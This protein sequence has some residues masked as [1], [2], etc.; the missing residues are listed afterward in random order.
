MNATAIQVISPKLFMG[1]MC[2]D[3]SAE[4]IIVYMENVKEGKQ[5]LVV[6][7]ARD[8]RTLTL[9]SRR[10]DLPDVD[11]VAV[12]DFAHIVRLVREQQP[13]VLLIDEIFMFPESFER[14]LLEL[15]LEFPELLVCMASL[16]RDFRGVPFE[17]TRRLVEFYQQSQVPIDVVSTNGAKCSV[18]GEPATQSQRLLDGAIAPWGSDLIE[19][20]AEQYQPRCDKCFVVP[21]GRP[22]EFQMPL[23]AY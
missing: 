13:D 1:P 18:C 17:I 10:Q 6:K 22:P 14:E 8:D 5:V 15:Q 12:R 4:L 16:V 20:G 9:W 11:C 3:K 7:P 2:S 21:P 23:W 19:V